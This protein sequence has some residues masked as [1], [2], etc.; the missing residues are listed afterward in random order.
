MG[1]AIS[2][3][4]LDQLTLGQINDTDSLFPALLPMTVKLRLI[5]GPSHCAVS[6]MAVIPLSGIAPASALCIPL[7]DMV[8]GFSVAGSSLLFSSLMNMWQLLSVA[9]A[10]LL[11]VTGMLMIDRHL[12]PP[13][14]FLCMDCGRSLLHKH[15]AKQRSHKNPCPFSLFSIFQTNHLIPFQIFK[16]FK[17]HFYA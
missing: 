12:Y 10:S 9:A 6:L 8:Q 14:L 17:I 1:K 4:G 7:M 15:K 16:L 5:A 13:G 11:A 2:G 3:I